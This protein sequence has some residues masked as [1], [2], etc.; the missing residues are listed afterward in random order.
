MTDFKESLI[1]W[2][3]EK[4]RQY[5]FANH[6]LV[7][8]LRYLH[9]Y[10]CR[11]C[12]SNF[13]ILYIKD[14]FLFGLLG[15]SASHTAPVSSLLIQLPFELPLSFPVFHGL[16][17]LLDPLSSSISF[18]FTILTL[19]AFVVGTVSLSGTSLSLSL[20]FSS[21][22]PEGLIFLFKFL[23][24]AVNHCFLDLLDFFELFL[25]IVWGAEYIHLGIFVIWR[26]F[27]SEEH[28]G[29][30]HIVV[31]LVSQFLKPLFELGSLYLLL[32]KIEVE[33]LGL[34]LSLTVFIYSGVLSLLLPSCEGHLL[35]DFEVDVF[36]DC[37]GLTVAFCTLLFAFLKL[38]C[39]QD[40]IGRME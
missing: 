10:L 35:G 21:E 34:N 5:D 8:T 23:L 9:V 18:I 39:A 1:L 30:V 29:E 11:G 14:G 26:K 6:T 25:I 15:P 19:L 4:L 22:L 20:V 12:I 32:L 16:L 3:L 37:L 40:P 33:L 27:I 24:D 17:H 7:L 28:F 36:Y 2:V 13:S 31:V 38:H